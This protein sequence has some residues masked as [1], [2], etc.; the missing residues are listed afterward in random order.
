M[1]ALAVDVVW[2]P[3]W[4]VC[5]LLIQS[6]GG[7]KACPSHDFKVQV[8]QREIH[9]CVQGRAWQ[10]CLRG[11]S[12]TGNKQPQPA[13]A[14]SMES[15]WSCLSKNMMPIV[16]TIANL[17]F[18]FKRST[19]EIP[20]PPTNMAKLINLVWFTRRCQHYLQPFAPTVS[21]LP[22][23][24]H[25]NKSVIC[26]TERNWDTETFCS[27]WERKG[28]SRIH[29]FQRLI[30][31]TRPSHFRTCCKLYLSQAGFNSPYNL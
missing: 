30:Y 29:G 12:G 31:D 9:G 5:V 27:W 26:F 10:W 25:R 14:M 4:Q 16:L 15:S 6:Q 17:T 24:M 22:F 21:S 1:L 19:K 28:R 7:R 20:R 11:G 13:V 23:S 8:R 18:M 2:G 3:L